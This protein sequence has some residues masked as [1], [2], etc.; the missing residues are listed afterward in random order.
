MPKQIFGVDSV[1][2]S[3]NRAFNDQSPANAVY[4]NQ[5]TQATSVG[6]NAF[7]LSFGSSFVGLT[8]DALSTKILGNLGVL[9]NTGLQAAV[10]DYLVSVGKANVGIVALQ[11]ADI[12]S[13][14][15][16]ATGDQAAFNAAAVKWNAEVTASY[17]YSANP[18]NTSA[19]PVGT[20][21]GAVTGVTLALTTADDFLSPQAAEA[22]FKTTANN[23]TIVATTVATLKSGDVIDGGAGTDT[24]RA[25]LDIAATQAP[26]VTNVENFFIKAT[27]LAVDFDLKNVTG[28]QQFWNE[29]SAVALTVKNAALGTTIGVKDTGQNTIVEFAKAT[30]TADA[31][32]VV[33]SGSTGG[34][35]QVDSIETLALQSTVK[36]NTTTIVGN[37]LETLT[38]TGDKGLTLTASGPAA[39]SLKT[40]D[41]SALTAAATITATGAVNA[42]TIKGGTAAD[43]IV[44]TGATKAV[45]VDGGTG[46]DTITLTANKAHSITL[47]AGADVLTLDVGSKAATTGSLTATDLTTAAKLIAASVKITDFA[48]GDTLILKTADHTTAANVTKLTGTIAENLAATGDLLNIIS[49]L[50]DTALPAGA[51]TTTTIA[52]QIGVNQA[53]SFTLAGNTYIFVNNNVATLDAGDVLIQL[54]GVAAPATITFA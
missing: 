17:T 38:V 9:P 16:N 14:L 12:L 25:T 29:E 10:K 35:V 34:N 7:A 13:G 15:E 3:L 36:A 27:A 41:A 22:K 54:T 30:G 51:G 40:I 26:T 46:A 45:T 47:G 19:S 1:V 11:L 6:N 4:N 49:D 8:E 21:D 23:D 50:T 53:V 39:A 33:L 42:L 44:A 28:I 48:A 5:V 52:T 32:T 31:A 18:A 37:T 43:T 24:L 20:D 2:T